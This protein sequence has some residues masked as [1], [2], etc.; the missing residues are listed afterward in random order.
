[1]NI[2]HLFAFFV[3]FFISLRILKDFAMKKLWV[4]LA[5]CLVAMVGCN[6]TDVTSEDFLDAAL[7]GV[8][9]VKIETDGAI[10]SQYSEYC[11]WILYADGTCRRCYFVVPNGQVN[12][13]LLYNTLNWEYDS[14]A[15]SLTITDPQLLSTA[16][17]TAVG[18]LYVESFNGTTFTLIGTLPTPDADAFE[19]K[20]LH[21]RIGS[22]EE[23]AEFEKKYV[24][25]G[26]TK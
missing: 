2:K 10:K 16:P 3:I 5:M 25:Q 18:T 7:E 6:N 17:D 12:Y 9:I 24:E 26:A 21:G 19:A 23:R 11:D 4:I 20:V 15:K 22:T 13:P 14:L 1:M 8:L